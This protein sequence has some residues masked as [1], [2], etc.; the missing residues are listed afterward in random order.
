MIL[1]Q[2][3]ERTSVHLRIGSVEPGTTMEFR[4]IE[5]DKPVDDS[6]SQKEDPLNQG[7]ILSCL[8]TVYYCLL[9]NIFSVNN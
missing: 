8:H 6:T 3:M 1:A 7:K 2:N 9:S 4:D 5:S